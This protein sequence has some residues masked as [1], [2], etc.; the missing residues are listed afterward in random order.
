VL[1]RPD[2]RSLR[3]AGIALTLSTAYLG[4]GLAAQHAMS[5]RVAAELNRQGVEYERINVTAAP[6]NTLLWRIVVM[7]PASYLQ[8]FASVLDPTPAIRFSEFP[9]RREHVAILESQ[10]AYQRLR[11]FTHGFVAAERDDDR[12]LV[13]DLRMGSE[14][15]YVFRFVLME[16]NGD[17]WQDVIPYR[18]EQPEVPAGFF[19]ALWRRVTDSAADQRMVEIAEASNQKHD[20]YECGEKQAHQHRC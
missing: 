8:G 18:L 4:W 20:P 17:A 2:G 16:K 15:A 10:P 3:A 12:L 13:K 5:G 14:P 7:T 9:A 6:F 19:A 1:F 11:W